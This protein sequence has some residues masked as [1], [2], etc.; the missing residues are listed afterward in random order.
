M[1]HVAENT[2][3]F[4]SK[5]NCKIDYETISKGNYN[6]VIVDDE[7][8]LYK[9]INGLLCNKEGDTLYF[10]PPNKTIINLPQSIKYFREGLFECVKEIKEFNHK[11]VYF[12]L[13]DN[14]LTYEELKKLIPFLRPQEL[15]IEYKKE[16]VNYF[17][18]KI[19]DGEV[20]KEIYTEWGKYMNHI[21]KRIYKNPRV[22]LT[23]ILPFLCKQ[24]LLRI[25]DI[26]DALF[27]CE[28]RRNLEALYTV[29]EYQRAHFTNE[30]IKVS[31]AYTLS[32]SVKRLKDNYHFGIRKDGT[33]L[34]TGYKGSSQDIVIPSNV[35]KSFITAF[36]LYT[37]S[38][39]AP[40]AYSD[41]RKKREKI[42]SVVIENPYIKELP[43]YV[44]LECK[45]LESVDL[46]EGL[47]IINQAAFRGCIS[48]VDINFPIT[49]VTI[50]ATS[51]AGCKN[52]KNINLPSSVKEI[53]EGA[54]ALCTSL[55]EVKLPETLETLGC[56]CFSHCTSLINVN[57]PHNFK[58]LEAC[59]FSGCIKLENITLPPSLISIESSVFKDCKSL[60]EISLPDTLKR[61]NYKAF[62]G[63]SSL[64]SIKLPSKIKALPYGVFKNCK[65]LKYVSLNDNL[66][67]IGENERIGGVFEGCEELEKIVIPEGVTILGSRTFME[68][69][70]L[71]EIVLPSTLKELGDYCFYGCKSLKA[72]TLPK[73]LKKIGKKCFAFCLS[74]RELYIN[75]N[76]KYVPQDAFTHSGIRKLSFP[77]KNIPF[78]ETSSFNVNDI[79]KMSVII[80]DK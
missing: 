7:N 23:L 79:K 35:G 63:C 43:C 45:M 38:P 24:H 15:C 47:E 59:L 65:K 52:L 2:S 36:L 13:K 16:I 44:F 8:P 20:K 11:N 5:D 61:I 72:I 37:F 29:Q 56:M 55:T 6:S 3:L 77:P 40:N 78:D 27:I 28:K 46:I 1:E 14:T 70:S 69:S 18:Q 51:F 4:I 12:S 75:D 19:V 64:T 26:P 53:Y 21:K 42:K 66:K 32:E 80:R 10:C 25:E 49:L 74:L 17:L 68:C 67:T 48:L 62:E 58:T 33:I 34:L 76:I 31:D 60:K 39:T 54:F 9:S 57:I 30:E 73:S 22:D 41:E 50:G 71:K